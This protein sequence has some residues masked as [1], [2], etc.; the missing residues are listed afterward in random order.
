MVS[1]L[2]NMD[3]KGKEKNNVVVI[4]NIYGKHI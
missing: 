3:I 2:R 4:D 1:D